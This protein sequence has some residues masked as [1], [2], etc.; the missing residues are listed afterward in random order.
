MRGP[1]ILGVVVEIVGYGDTRVN[2]SRVCTRIINSGLE[3]VNSMKTLLYG[4]QSWGYDGTQG[5]VL[6]QSTD[7]GTDAQGTWWG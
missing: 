4:E 7:A 3:K 6:I 5:W 2:K 1:Y